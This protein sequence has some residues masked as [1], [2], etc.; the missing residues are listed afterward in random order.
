MTQSYTHVIDFSQLGPKLLSGKCLNVVIVLFH[1]LLQPSNDQ[2]LHARQSLFSPWSE[3]AVSKLPEAFNRSL[4]LPPHFLTPSTFFFSSVMNDLHTYLNH[5][6]A[7]IPQLL[8]LSWHVPRIRNNSPEVL[9]VILPHLLHVSFQLDHVPNV[10][11]DHA[12]PLLIPMLLFSI[13]QILLLLQKVVE[14]LC[15][16]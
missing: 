14:F 1:T 16:R 4:S 13:P 11:L 12:S 10:R 3:T 8:S 15:I 7:N 6:H 9:S 2:V 5:D